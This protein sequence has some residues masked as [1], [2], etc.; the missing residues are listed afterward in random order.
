[1]G[2]S[3]GVGGN[4][5]TKSSSSAPKA[6][7]VSGEHITLM[8]PAEKRWFERTRDDYL[9]QTRFSETTDLRDVDRLL[10]HELLIYRWTSWIASGADYDGH[11]IDDQEL[12]RN[13]K[14]YSSAVT[15][16]KDSMGLTKKARDAQADKGSV[17]DYIANLKD[18]AKV[19]GIHR[20][21]QLVKALSLMEELSTVV[22][23]FHRSDEEER[24][25]MGFED[26]AEIV[27]WITNTMLPEYRALDEHF[28]KNDQRYW[29]KQL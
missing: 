25:K 22:G 13:I 28:R 19:F 14:L 4:T 7:L 17:A 10:V 29:V 18:K 9:Q 23:A 12:Q 5:T 8:S 3:T 20:E 2:K 21:R 1:M 11:L 15:D 26:E 24:R 16:I 6:K 27:G